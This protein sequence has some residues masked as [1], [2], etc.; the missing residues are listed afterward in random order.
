MEEQ[1]S[2]QIN[3]IFERGFNRSKRILVTITCFIILAV[4]GGCGRD[5]PKQKKPLSLGQFTEISGVSISPDG[6]QLLFVGCG[7]KDYAAC[8]IY[9]FD[10]SGNALYRYLPRRPTEMLFDGRVSPASNR[11]TFSIIP[12]DNKEQRDYDNTQI[13]IMN[14][15]GSGFKI[16]TSGSSL[17]TSSVLS[18]DENKLPF[19]KSRMSHN[20][21]PLRKQ[22][23]KSVGYDL[24]VLNLKTGKETRLT[25]YGFYE[26]SEPYFTNDNK[27]ILYSGDSPMQLPNGGDAG[28]YRDKYKSKYKQNIIF[29][30]SVDGSDI[31]KELSPYFKLSYGSRMPVLMKDGTIVF[32][33]RVGIHEG[34]IHYYK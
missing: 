3:N 12:Y 7:H 26:V 19:F 21:S 8:T 5:Y 32:E 11:F 20:G 17:K 18:Y 31:T 1:V 30:T 14:M 2:Y 33:G 9:R 28:K 10:R 15:D 6:T 4:S 25:N 13:A 16:V 27:K 34:F 24:Y 22:K 23:S 29:V